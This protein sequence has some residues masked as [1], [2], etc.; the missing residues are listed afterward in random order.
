MDTKHENE[1]LRKENFLGIGKKSA[2]KEKQEIMEETN[3]L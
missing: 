2:E 1:H 3:N